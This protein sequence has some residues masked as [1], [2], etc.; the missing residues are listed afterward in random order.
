MSLL[1]AG[2]DL[3]L[4]EHVAETFIANRNQSGSAMKSNDM[5]SYF[6]RYLPV[7]VRV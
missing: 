6:V 4:L 5:L 2:D 7:S 1:P 3:H